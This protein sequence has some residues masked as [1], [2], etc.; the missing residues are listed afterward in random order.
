MSFT[1]QA[2]SKPASSGAAPLA[3]QKEEEVPMSQSIFP[4]M[5]EPSSNTFPAGLRDV[6]M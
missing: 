3:T 2:S 5:Q 4:D 1:N 6:F